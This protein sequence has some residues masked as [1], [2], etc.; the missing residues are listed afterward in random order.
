MGFAEDMA[1]FAKLTK[2]RIDVVVRK[3]ALDL[4]KSAVSLSPVDKGQFRG[5]WMVG[6]DAVD[7]QTVSVTDLTGELS[8]A[9]TDAALA[10]WEPGQTIYLT[11]SMPQAYV[12]EFGLYGNPPGS[13]NGDKTVGGF[14]KQAPAGMV[15]LTTQNFKDYVREAVESAK[16]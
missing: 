5:N 8:I 4:Q 11:N 12:I 3:S 13:A 15:R 7:R 9:R 14:S 1:E 10:K 16:R 6:M 2:Q